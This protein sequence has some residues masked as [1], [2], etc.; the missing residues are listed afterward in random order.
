[1]SQSVQQ[2]IRAAT[3]SRARIAIG[4]QSVTLARK[5]REAAQGM[6]DEGLSDYLRVLDAEDRL[7]QAERS[8]LNGQVQYFL[9]TVRV[10]RTLGEDITQ[11]LPE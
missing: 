7:V 10:R 6:Y 2:Q 11:G 8:L 4:E 5:N 9:T 3:S 1:V